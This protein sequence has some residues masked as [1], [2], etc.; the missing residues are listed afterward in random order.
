MKVVY[1]LQDTRA[2]YGAEQATVRLVAGVA[3]AGVAVRVLL[4]RETRLGAGPSPLAEALRR[5]APVEEIPVVGR[6]SRAAVARIRAVMAQERAAVLHSTGY[7]ADWHAAFASK[8][9]VLFPVVSTVHGWLFRW[10]LKERLFQYLNLAALR[11][12][13]RVIVLCGFYERYLRRRGLTPLQLAR[14]P[15]GVQAD[16]IVSRAEA[17]ARGA[18]PG[19]VFTFGLLGRL[20]SEK[21]HALLLRAAARLARDLDTSPRSWRIRIAGAGPLRGTLE[22]RIARLGLAERVELAGWLDAPEFFRRVDV[23]VQCSRVE[24]QPLSVLEAMAWMRPTIATRAGGLPELV[25][26]GQTGRLVP[27]R[28]VRALAAAMK[29]YLV[30]PERAR[31]DGLRARERLEAEYPFGRMVADHVGLYEAECRG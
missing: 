22:K 25:V 14:I 27:T 15:T 7:K 23:L 6:F 17:R 30:A 24:N 8:G 1:L 12:F 11:R 19:D 10:N 3:A 5:R 21:N 29:E 2:L 20:S 16:G 9:G 31:A 13:N 4:L 18:P 26:D 28:G